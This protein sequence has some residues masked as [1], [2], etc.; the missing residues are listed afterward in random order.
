MT[1]YKAGTLSE[2]MSENLSL[3]HSQDSGTNKRK[4]MQNV[5]FLHATLLEFCVSHLPQL[6]L[7][8]RQR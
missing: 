7:H 1:G 4:N 6:S 8:H 2:N 5:T 3:Y